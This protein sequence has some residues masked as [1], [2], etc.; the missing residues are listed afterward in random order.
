MLIATEVSLLLGPF[1]ENN[2]GHKYIFLYSIS[3][4]NT[5]HEFTPT[6]LFQFNNMES[7]LVFPSFR[8]SNSVLR[9]WDAWLP[10]SLT[11]LSGPVSLCYQS[12]IV[13]ASPSPHRCS[14]H[15][16]L[17]QYPHTS[18]M[19]KT[20]PPCSGCYSSCLALLKEYAHLA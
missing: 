3:I 11:L 5:N 18:S 1:S 7:I 2:L 14:L 4:Y 12:P 10:L 17:P 16:F 8:N 13:A 6:S 15:P 19:S 20:S 9:P